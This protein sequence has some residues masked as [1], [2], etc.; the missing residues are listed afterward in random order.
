MS[1]ITELI[2]SARYGLFVRFD[3][4]PGKEEDVDRLLRDALDIVQQEEPSTTTWF[5]LQFG[6][7]SFGIF[8]TFQDPDAR[9]DHLGGKIAAALMESAPELLVGPPTIETI[10]ILYAKRPEMRRDRAA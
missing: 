2:R 5:A 6:P 8:D 4:K 10:D 1:E 9:E 3:A 7:S